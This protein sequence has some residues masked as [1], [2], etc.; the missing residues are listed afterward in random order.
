MK[1]IRKETP[2]LASFQAKPPWRTFSSWV[3]LDLPCGF[4]EVE[5]EVEELSEGP[6]QLLEQGL[7]S[8]KVMNELG[9]NNLN[10]N[11]L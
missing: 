3:R 7:E 8:L 2:Q 5:V 9:A 6:C 11:L 10:G 4:R 1:R